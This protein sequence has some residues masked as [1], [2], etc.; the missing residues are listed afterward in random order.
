M[1]NNHDCVFDCGK[2]ARTCGLLKDMEGLIRIYNQCRPAYGILRNIVLLVG[3]PL[4]TFHAYLVPDAKGF[5]WPEFARI[6]FW[7]FPCPILATI[8]L[9]YG[10][11]CSGMYLKTEDEKWDARSMAGHELAM[12]FI[13]LTMISGIFFSRIQWNAWWQNDPRQVSFLIVTCMYFAY[14]VLRSA[15]SDPV[16][17]A[18]NSAGYALAAFLPF[19][20][21]TFVYTRLPQVQNNHPNDTIMKGNLKGGYA[22][23]TIEMM[24]LVP[25]VA[26]WICNLRSRA[27]ILEQ[28]VKKYGDLQ[29]THSNTT[30]TPVVR[31][32][33]VSDQS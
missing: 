10:A 6:F 19:L 16:R 8:L 2:H 25:M 1:G 9:T 11:I 12:I 21:L 23:V 5:L 33:S 29:S 20:F 26:G 3:I 14:F 4:V 27:A 32:I 22:W 13:V 7:H 30:D 18:T 31:R 17:R 24:F 15:L 28:E